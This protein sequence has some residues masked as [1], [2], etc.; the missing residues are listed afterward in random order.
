MA[1]PQLASIHIFPVKSLAGIEVDHWPVHKRGLYLDRHWMIIDQNGR[2]L[3]QRTLPRMALIKVSLGQETLKLSTGDMPELSVP[4][5][6]DQRENLEATI[7]RDSCTARCVGPEADAWL[8]KALE[9]D[10]RLV[11]LPDDSKRV[12]DQDYAKE[13]DEVGFAD[14]FPFMLIGSAT[15]DEL[16]RRLAEPVEM[17]RFRPNLVIGTDTPHIEDQWRQITVGEI[18][19]RLPK[20]CARCIATTVDPD[21]G[22]RSSGE[23]L[24][25]LAT[26]RAGNN[27]I[28]FGQNALHDALGTLSRGDQVEIIETGEPQPNL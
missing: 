18:P 20:P 15:L 27:K 4:F 11:Y 21:K 23:P 17:R 2:F 9:Q 10:C 7:W 22:Q 1:P 8:S 16:N 6:P 19:F 12:V 3:S 14:G 24:K 13:A 5:E 26:Y 28:Y 25:T